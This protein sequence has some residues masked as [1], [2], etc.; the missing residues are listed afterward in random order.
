[1]S[2][3]DPESLLPDQQPS[4]RDQRRQPQIDAAKHALRHHFTNVLGGPI[5]SAYYLSQLQ[6]LYEQDFFPWVLS[7]AV[8]QLIDEGFLTKLTEEDIP[9]ISSLPNITRIQFLINSRAIA[10]NPNQIKKRCRNTATLVNR[11]SS[12]VN[13]DMI[14]KHLESLVRAELRAQSFTIE[15]SH[16]NSFNRRQWTRT[17]H[18]LDFI[19]THSSGHLSIGVEVKNT[20]DMIEA[21]E[22]D[23]KIEICKFLGIIPVFAVR[24]IKPYINCINRQGGFSWVFKTQMYPLG[25]DKFVR[26]LFARLS[27][28]N[29]TD[30]RGHELQFP[31]TVRTELPPISVQKFQDWVA[32]AIVTPPVVNTNVKCASSH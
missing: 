13:S 29:R 26:E 21:E 18:N 4:T 19:A 31:V 3:Y 2:Y 5:R 30:A 10:A 6:I 12:P 15:G 25:Q 1:V 14:G 24:W 22:I 27:V 7:D 11:Y 20:L 17:D 23:I 9:E 32:R 16:T 8:K 28:T